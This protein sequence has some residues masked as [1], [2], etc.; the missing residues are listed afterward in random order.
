MMRFLT[1]LYIATA[2]GDRHLHI[3]SLVESTSGDAVETRSVQNQD[4]AGLKRLANDI[5]EL[6]ST[7]EA[8]LTKSSHACTVEQFGSASAD[9]FTGHDLCG[10]LLPASGCLV[11]TYG[12]AGDFSFEAALDRRGCRVASFDPTVKYPN[13]LPNTTVDF[14]KI[15]APMLGNSPF[16]VA[17]PV[18]MLKNFSVVANQK[19]SV[20]KMD[21]EG[22]EYAIAKS[23]EAERPDFF[24]HVDQ[25]AVE[26]HFVP[27]FL[28][29]LST[30]HEYDKLLKLLFDAGL[31]L[32]SV[33]IGA[34]GRHHRQNF[35]D[36]ELT[37][38]VEDSKYP[39]GP[40][41]GCQNFL[42]VRD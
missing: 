35:T 27:P 21:C 4:F 12:I 14:L 28:T 20:L 3:H 39:H 32:R 38:A 13:K 8:S 18:Q 40:F 37:K 26:V 23:V 29:T 1:Y 2:L 42:F 6:E 33:K 30:L 25:F 10:K 31:R 17:S 36:K 41:K 34:C 11:L 15:G 19:L 24:R 7:K 22:C 16:A 9:R 5:A